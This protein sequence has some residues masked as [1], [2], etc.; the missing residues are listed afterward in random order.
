[1]NWRT[2]R[3]STYDV[4]C[5]VRYVLTTLPPATYVWS[6]NQCHSAYE[7]SSLQSVLAVC[8]D[9]ILTSIATPK[10]TRFILTSRLRRYSSFCQMH[11]RVHSLRTPHLQVTCGSARSLLNSPP[12]SP[13]S[14]PMQRRRVR[15]ILTP[16]ILSSNHVIGHRGHMSTMTSREPLL[17]FRL[18]LPVSCVIPRLLLVVTRL[19]FRR[20]LVR[21]GDTRSDEYGCHG[22]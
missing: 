6:Q 19:P 2:Y 20:H 11:H 5:P 7:N 15:C 18:Q 12:C 10:T 17:R 1:M 8:G 3:Q 16:G 14:T 21:D 13:P 22:V 4:C 9:N